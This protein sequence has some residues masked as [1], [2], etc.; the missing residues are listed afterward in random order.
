MSEVFEV[1]RLARA[2]GWKIVVSHRSGETDDTFVAD[3]AFGLGAF[4][5]KAGAPTQRERRV[6]YE[7]LNVIEDEFTT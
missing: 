6:K 5:L 7:R 3:L 2:A 4:G 1:A